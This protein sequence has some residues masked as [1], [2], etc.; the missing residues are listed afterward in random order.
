MLYRLSVGIT[1]F[2]G[3]RINKVLKQ[4]SN[5]SNITKFP[6]GI[7]F[8]SWNDVEDNQLLVVNIP[9]TTQC[10]VFILSG[11]DY[12]GGIGYHFVAD[13][14]AVLKII[15]QPNKSEYE[16]KLEVENLRLKQPT[17]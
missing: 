2:S 12:G 17:A 5:M 14:E 15:E 16:I 1:V 3:S 9:D 13:S 11:C 10:T 6:G 4:L 7:I 8:G